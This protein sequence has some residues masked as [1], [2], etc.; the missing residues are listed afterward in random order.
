MTPALLLS[1]TC[2]H[3]ETMPTPTL[4]TLRT[5]EVGVVVRARGGKIAFGLPVL[6]A[7]A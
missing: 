3:R 7:L 5:A 2:A 1:V 4:D 6:V